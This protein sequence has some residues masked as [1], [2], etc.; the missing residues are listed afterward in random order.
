MAKTLGI[1]VSSVAVRAAD[2]FASPNSTA[3]DASNGS[4]CACAV[5][6]HPFTFLN[7]CY[8]IHTLHSDRTCV[9]YVPS[10]SYSRYHICASRIQIT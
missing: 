9:R 2:N 3:T 8:T 10:V 4:E 5:N 7:C 1:P 6:A